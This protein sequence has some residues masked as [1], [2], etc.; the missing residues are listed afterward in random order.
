MNCLV[1]KSGQDG[2]KIL[3]Q[4]GNRVLHYPSERRP[5]LAASKN[6][7]FDASGAVVYQDMSRGQQSH[8]IASQDSQDAYHAARPEQSRHYCNAFVHNIRTGWFTDL[9]S[10]GTLC[11]T[12]SADTASQDPFADL[13]GLLP[14]WLASMLES[15]M[16]QDF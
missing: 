10:E 3:V 15:E 7:V 11:S 9:V 13:D 5:Y 16:L 14:P 2:L 8:R 1:M 12:T 4:P 6:L